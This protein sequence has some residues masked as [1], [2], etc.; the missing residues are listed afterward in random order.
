MCVY[1]EVTPTAIARRA[2]IHPTTIGKITKEG[3][4]TND[5]GRDT[6]LAICQAMQQVAQEKGKYWYP[7]WETMMHNA[8]G[9]ATY[10]QILDA[11]HG[12]D[13]IPLVRK[14]RKRRK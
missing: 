13:T 5:P 3:E 2:E 4:H 6:A 11:R 10:E 14:T 7:A 1:L 8:A 12:L 9:L